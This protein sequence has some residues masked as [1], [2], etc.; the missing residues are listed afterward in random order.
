M[1][2]GALNFYGLPKI[3]KQGTPLI[4]IVSSILSV[5]YG[6]AEDLTKILKYLPGKSPHYINSTQDIAEHIK[7]ETLISGECLSSCD[8]SVLF[9]SVPVDSAL[10]IIKNLLEKDPT[11]KERTVMS[12]RNIVL[13]LEFCLKI[14]T[15]L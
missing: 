6:V 7:N 12:V 9:T 8:I 13:L 2:C 3:H 14:L 1:G 5:I 10:G 4:P 11:L 15:S